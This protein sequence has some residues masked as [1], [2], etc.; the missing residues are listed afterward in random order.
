MNQNVE[1]RINVERLPAITYLAELSKI[2]LLIGELLASIFNPDLLMLKS[3][4]V[5]T[6]L[7]TYK[8]PTFMFATC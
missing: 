4:D 6:E 7:R 3:L 1:P 5:S 2:P 8:T